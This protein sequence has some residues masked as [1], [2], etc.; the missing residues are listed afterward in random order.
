MA[1]AYTRPNRAAWIR[2]RARRLAAFWHLSRR[3]AVREAAEDFAGFH[4]RIQ[5]ALQLVKG[6]A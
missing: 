4:G 2:R 5:P 3:E 1:P 6:G